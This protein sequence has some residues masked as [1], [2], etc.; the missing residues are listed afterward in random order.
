MSD[1]I[2]TY[3]QAAKQLLLAVQTKCSDSHE[4]ELIKKK[5]LESY[6]HWGNTVYEKA[7]LNWGLWD[8]KIAHEYEQ[9]NFDFSALCPYQDI[10][11]QLLL[12]SLIR[13]LFQ[14]NLFNKRLLEIGCGNGIGLRMSSII[15]QSSYAVGLDL[16]YKLVSN[17]KNNFYLE[18]QV[19]YVQSDAES[20][21]FANNSFDIL[22]NLESSHLYPRVDHFFSEVARVLTPGG[23]F[24]YADIYTGT[25]Q[26]TE[27]LEQFINNRNDLTIVQ[28][29]NI[30]REVQASIYRRLIIGEEG[31]YTMASAL[32]GNDLDV[33][34][35]ELPSLA[36]AMGLSFLPWWKRALAKTDKLESIIKAAPKNTFWDGKKI[37]FYY[38][39]QKV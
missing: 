5:V 19:N 38:L 20:L 30:T 21:P 29:N 27:H 28:K 14:L 3:S 34:D 39:I 8:K 25:K 11:S 13:P 36:Y 23:F 1:G 2:K 32:F 18:E 6:T 16:V 22:T 33:L 15:M 26:Q 9:L 17:A 24:C 31:F 37:F 35:S 7:F 12:Y 4:A 10:Q